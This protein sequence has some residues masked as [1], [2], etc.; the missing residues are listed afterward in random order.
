M[1]LSDK[2]PSYFQNVYLLSTRNIIFIKGVCYNK[3]IAS[4][5][6]DP[7]YGIYTNNNNCSRQDC[8]HTMSI[9]KNR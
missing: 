7:L 6:T 4:F 2:R 3:L 8:L 9:N 5:V 1:Y